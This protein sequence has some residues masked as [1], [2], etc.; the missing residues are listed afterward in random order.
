METGGRAD[1]LAFW[2]LKLE[3]KLRLKTFSLTAISDETIK[4]PLSTEYCADLGLGS[5][6]LA[7]QSIAH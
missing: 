4:S 5:I 2:M 1:R 6:S 3:L 7:A